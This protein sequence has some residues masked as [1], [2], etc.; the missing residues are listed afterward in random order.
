MRSREYGNATRFVDGHNFVLNSALRVR[1]V[2]HSE[3]F[4]RIK[5]NFPIILIAA[6]IS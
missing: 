2:I 4:N 6:Y 3:Y 1:E 5:I